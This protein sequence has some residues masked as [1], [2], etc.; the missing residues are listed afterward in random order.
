MKLNSCTLSSR[1]WTGLMDSLAKTG[2]GKGE[3]VTLQWRNHT[4]HYFSQLIQF[5]SSVM[6][7]RSDVRKRILHICGILSKNSQPQFNHEKNIKETQTAGFS[8]G[9]MANSLQYFASL[10][11]KERLRMVKLTLCSWWLT[12]ETIESGSISA[13]L[14]FDFY[15]QPNS[16]IK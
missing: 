1:A 14:T 5:M 6:S 16:Q 12:M 8:A 2:V 10:K 11:N 9:Y 15:I 3:I 13:I 4:L 7:C